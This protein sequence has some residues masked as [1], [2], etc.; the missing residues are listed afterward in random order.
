MPDTD[1]LHHRQLLRIVATSQN[2]AKW[3]VV[4]VGQSNQIVRPRVAAGSQPESGARLLGAT[5]HHKLTS[6]AQTTSLCDCARLQALLAGLPN[7]Q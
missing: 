7:P 3:I 2:P 5:I 1:V 4:T 6:D